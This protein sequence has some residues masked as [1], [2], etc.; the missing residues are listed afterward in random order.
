VTGPVRS[1][2]TAKSTAAEVLAGRD[3]SGRT[4]VVTGGASGIGYETSLA[5]AAAGACVL[6]A[7]RDPAAGRTA[8]EAISRETGNPEVLVGELDLMRP[9]SVR[10]CA[11]WIAAAAPKLDALIANAGISYTPDVWTP[12]GLEQ[13]FATNHLGH[14]QLAGLLTPQLR[15]AAPSRV[16]VVSSAAHKR[17][18]VVFEDIHYRE[19]PFD[20]FDAYGQSKTANILYAMAFSRR[21]GGDGVLANALAPGSILTRLQRHIAKERMIVNGLLTADGSPSPNLK[22]AAQGAAT[23]VWAAAGPELEGIGGLYL[24]NCREAEPVKPQTAPWEGWAD[25]ARDP[26]AAERL[27]AVT[28]ALVGPLE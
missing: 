25:H 6:L 4:M 18:P 13:R 21:F 1:P 16:V 24:E 10:A 28:E 12:E 19:R 22:T 26:A 2:F 23:S 27:W 5:L 17:S 7:V 15:A 14:A 8:A 3:L 20:P 11:A 9:A